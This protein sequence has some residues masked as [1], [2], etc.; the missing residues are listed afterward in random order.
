MG[1][2]NP[3][4]YKVEFDQDVAHTCSIIGSLNSGSAPGFVMAGAGEPNDPADTVVVTTQSR[5]FTF[6]DNHFYVTALC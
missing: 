5:D 3:G 1:R 6:V 2:T 4:I